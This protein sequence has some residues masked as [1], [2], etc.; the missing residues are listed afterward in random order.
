MGLVGDPR[1]AKKSA[2]SLRGETVRKSGD[3]VEN[4]LLTTSLH[5]ALSLLA[6]FN[7]LYN[8]LFYYPPSSF[9]DST[10]S[11]PQRYSYG[12]GRPRSTSHLSAHTCR[13]GPPSL[14]SRLTLRIRQRLRRSLL[15]RQPHICS[16]LGH[17]ARALAQALLPSILGLRD[18]LQFYPFLSAPRVFSVGPPYIPGNSGATA[19][20]ACIHR[21]PVIAT[22][23]R[24]AALRWT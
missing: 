10:L 15:R 19:L 2:A 16:L 8:I 23:K 1:A 22:A 7:I 13:P 3:E 18:L 11:F 5:R 14:A 12:P 24:R 6:P 9:C 4:I 17:L 21:L 20:P